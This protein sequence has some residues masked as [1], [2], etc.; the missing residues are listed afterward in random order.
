[1]INYTHEAKKEQKQAE[2][3]KP[4]RR[5]FSPLS[6]LQQINGKNKINNSHIDIIHD[7]GPYQH[8]MIIKSIKDNQL[9][10]K[11]ISIGIG[12]E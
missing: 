10:Q 12:P 2:Y 4:D 8:K 9:N 5:K 3:R 7:T 11:Q 6:Y 1:M